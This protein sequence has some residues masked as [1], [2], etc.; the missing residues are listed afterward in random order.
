MLTML[1]INERWHDVYMEE[2]LAWLLGL[3][4]LALFI[5]VVMCDDAGLYRFMPEL[6][7]GAAVAPTPARS[8]R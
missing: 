2:P 8:R 3:N 6:A 1:I 4:L 7:G 5:D